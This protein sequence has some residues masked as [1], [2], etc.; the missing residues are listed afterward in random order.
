MHAPRPG[1]APFLVFYAA[2]TGIVWGTHA[3]Q[4]TLWQDDAQHLFRVFSEPGGP[5]AGA[6]IQSANTATRTL[7]AVPF[8]LALLT[9]A[10]REALQALYGGVWLATAWLAHGLA[11]RLF[12]GAVA[13]VVAGSLAATATSDF[14][15]NSLVA[16]PGLIAV[17]LC[18]AGL[19]AAL[20]WLDGASAPWLVAAVALAQAGLFTC[21]YPVPAV[22]LAPGL[23][24]LARGRRA[25]RRWVVG[26]F[27]WYATSIPYLI[28]L[29]LFLSDRSGYAGTAVQLGTAAGLARR[30]ATL[31]LYNF[32]PWTWAF[33]RAQWLPAPEPTL[34]FGVRAAGAALGAAVFAAAL[35]ASRGRAEPPRHSPLVISAACLGL[36]LAANA[37][38]ATVSFADSFLRTHLHSRLWAAV[39]LGG[40]AGLAARRGPLLRWA[41]ASAGVAFVG[42]GVWGGLERQDYFLGYSRRHGQELRSILSQVPGLAPQAA[43]MLQAPPHRHLLATGAPYLARAWMTLLYEDPSL[44]CRVFLWS[45]SAGATCQAEADGFLCR[46][47]TSPRCVPASLPRQQRFAYPRVVMLAYDEASNA[48]LPARS[49]LPPPLPAAGA[50]VVPGPPSALARDL[51]GAGGHR[52]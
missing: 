23:F 43:L 14:L 5:L 18:A 7:L 52:P 2:L 38:L 37:S 35:R 49:A 39:G 17:G 32:T 47:E 26:T 45:D 10:P 31:F 40:L 34:S 13:P 33:H 16:L 4:R 22:L 28:L 48:W 51:V 44:E 21:E 25:D 1:H 3:F 29:A 27:V 8:A 42:L 24:W 30:T 15:T 20:R 36:A 46:G 41:A 6:F 11:R 19:L 50:L 9:G 12:G